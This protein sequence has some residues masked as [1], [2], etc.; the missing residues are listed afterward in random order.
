MKKIPFRPLVTAALVSM[1]MTACS[2]APKQ[3]DS[4]NQAR[5]AYEKASQDVTLVRHAPEE[6]DKARD[7]LDVAERRWKQDEKPADVEHFSYLA[8]QRVRIAEQI[9]KSNEMDRELSDMALE[10]RSVT[11]DL[12]EAEL[13]KVKLEAKALQDQMKNLKAEKTERGMVLTL[14]D[15]LFEVNEATMAPG[16]GRNIAKIASFMR[17]YPERVAV[18]EGH[19]DSMGDDEYNL[20]LSRDRAFSIRRALINEGISPS[21]ITTQGF[22]EALPVASNTNS[23]GRQKNRRVEIIFP[24]MPTQVS[25]FE[26]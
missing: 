8:S 2:S 1:A 12:R 26:E 21:R 5:A 9:A 22:G 4:L 11:L 6:L 14:G 10:R 3:N 16:A 17:S 25:E 20:S 24:D 19:T 13:S 23:A 7:A 15:V 18:I